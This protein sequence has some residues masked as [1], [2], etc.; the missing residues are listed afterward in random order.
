L[1]LRFL[2]AD[3]AG[4]VADYEA[5]IQFELVRHW[6][7]K[8]SENKQYYSLLNFCLHD[9]DVFTISSTYTA[10]IVQVF[11]ESTGRFLRQSQELPWGTSA[12]LA[13]CTHEHDHES[14]VVITSQ[15]ENPHLTLLRVDTLAV[16]V[17]FPAYTDSVGWIHSMTSIDSAVFL[18][19]EYADARISGSTLVSI[20]TGKQLLYLSDEASA[21][22]YMEE[23]KTL[24]ASDNHLATVATYKKHTSLEK[25]KR[26]CIQRFERRGK[27]HLYGN[28][29]AL[30]VH[31]D[32]VILSCSKRDSTKRKVLVFFDLSHLEQEITTCWPQLR[33]EVS[34]PSPK[35]KQQRWFPEALVINKRKNELLVCDT[36]EQ[37]NR[38]LVYK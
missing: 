29:L 3:V 18:G 32:T 12:C 6:K 19:I 14:R 38:V 17:E 2:H 15:G 5:T 33:R 26:V 27:V 7:V 31:G 36:Y 25:T 21:S 1:L 30:V 24:F 35:L 9:H 20:I 23:T 11:E 28:L 16:A 4:I 8:D 37:S 10:I 34:S 13:V 22:F